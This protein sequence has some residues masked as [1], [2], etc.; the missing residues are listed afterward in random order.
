MK[1]KR[2]LFLIFFLLLIPNFIYAET[3][4]K[5]TNVDWL[6][7]SRKEKE[8]YIM[9]SMKIFQTQGI[10]LRKTSLQY[11]SEID[12]ITDSPTLKPTTVDNI[13]TTI[14]LIGEPG[15][16]NA[17]NQLNKRPEIKK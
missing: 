12:N 17:M 4:K 14:V 15:S 13:F 7:M 11:L 9:S 16:R 6:L 8:D 10:S 1:I 3:L 2:L 5:I